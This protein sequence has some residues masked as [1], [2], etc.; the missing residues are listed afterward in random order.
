MASK[1]SGWFPGASTITRVASW[2]A[3]VAMSSATAVAGSVSSMLGYEDLQVVEAEPEG[4]VDNSK[5]WATGHEEERKAWWP[6]LKEYIGKDIMSLMSV[7]VFIMEP[8]SVLQKMAEIMEYSELLDKAAACDDPEVRLLYVAAFAIGAYPSNERTYKPF[9]PLLGETFE[10]KKEDMYYLA[11]QVSHH[12]PV[13]AGHAEGKGWTY[14]ITSAPRT[15]FY[16]NYIDVFPVGR[17]RIK[18]R[19]EV[20][21]IYPPQSRINNVLMGRTWIDHFGELT[22]VNLTNNMVCDLVFEQCGWFG[23]NRYTVAGTLFGPDDAPMYTL[24]GKW[25]TGVRY[26]R[27]DGEGNVVA[28]APWTDLWKASENPKAD[29]GFTQF[30]RLLNKFDS[31][32]RNMLAS[33]ARLRPDR[34]ALDDGEMGKAGS[35]KHELEEQQR[36]E[37]RRRED[38]GDTWAPR[39][40]R[41]AADADN[42]EEID[43]DIW[44]FTGSY[45]ERTASAPAV[46]HAAMKFSPWQYAS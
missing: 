27:C 16:G 35:A 41:V 2:S 17:T 24:E 28:G 15:K 29:Y 5:N 1:K 6:R 38:Q 9:N 39:W 44:E 18:I 30:A 32:P 22:V 25:N 12:P 23:A 8:F 33:D 45:S 14:D 13:G 40:F 37:R 34:Q 43:T 20:Y 7:P 11:E 42:N 3:S 10:Y 4:T 26:S 31:A 46:E 36:A 21:A 19:D